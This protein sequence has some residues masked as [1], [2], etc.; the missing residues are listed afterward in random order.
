MPKY[1]SNDDELFALARKELFVALVGDILDTKGYVHQFLD[2]K[3]K[4]I[5][6]HMV[7]I[8]RAMPV[9]EADFFGDKNKGN[10]PLSEKPFG[11]MFEALDDLKKNEVYV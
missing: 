11:Y 1:W 3:L 9:L 5:D 7:I 10:N 2:P 6:D 8:G 4:P